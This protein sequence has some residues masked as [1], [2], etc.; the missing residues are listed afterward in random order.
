MTSIEFSAEKISKEFNRRVI[1]QDISFALRQTESLAITGRNGA[2]KS[3]LA[4]ILCGLL[5]PTKG[6]IRCVVRGKEIPITD[7]YKNVGFV[8]PYINLYDEFSGYEN[9]KI[10]ANIRNI[11][12]FSA[13]DMNA[14]LQQFNIYARRNDDVRT[15]SSGMK[16]RLK[17]CA[18][19]LHHPSIL[20][21]DE[22]TSN[23]DQEGI[24][25][26]RSVMK[27]YREE[28]ILIIATNDADDVAFADS[29]ISLE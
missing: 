15:Y 13:D 28:G 16:Q 17:Y 1:F 14:V 3:T 19:L 24:A 23:L 22:P 12:N 25:T 10:I 26:V 18:A 6:N 4:K 7:V 21:L 2:G 8:A 29:T 11:P 27:R 9:L 20:I 5:T